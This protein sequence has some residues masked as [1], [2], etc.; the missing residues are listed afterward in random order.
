MKYKA[1]A[2]E[3]A[4]IIENQDNQQIEIPN[5]VP[6][7]RLITEKFETII[8]L[9]NQSTQNKTEDEFQTQSGALITTLN[10]L[11]ADQKSDS[12]FTDFLKTAVA[13]DKNDAYDN[14]KIMFVDLF[15]DLHKFFAMDKVYYKNQVPTL[16]DKDSSYLQSCMEI[17][18]NALSAHV[19]NIIT[20]L[21]VERASLYLRNPWYI[22]AMLKLKE[23]RHMRKRK[24]HELQ[25]QSDDDSEQDTNKH[26]KQLR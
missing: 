12:D 16:A 14:E 8:K 10:R 18:K 22:Q 9:F 7:F 15:K 17:V 5:L 13:I 3:K 6:I 19:K 2:Q 21:N 24:F 11:V 25:S 4:L 26:T 1:R 20:G 23:G